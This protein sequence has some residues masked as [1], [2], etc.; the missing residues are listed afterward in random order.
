M[1]SGKLDLGEAGFV[2]EVP[3]QRISEII[4]AVNKALEN[5]VDSMKTD[6]SATPLLVV[7]GGAMLCPREMEGISEVVNVMHADVA[8]AVGAA[9]AQISGEVD[10][11]FHNM[12]RDDLLL[13]AKKI[14]TQRAVSAGAKESTVRV[15]DVEDLPL[16][17]M[18]GNAVRAR[19]RVVGDIGD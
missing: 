14:A 15:V 11:V 6:S 2:I 3:E 16:A 4:N 5:T 1:A 8:N 19:V 12:S 10:R 18:P 13:E 9:M 17:Y 7:G